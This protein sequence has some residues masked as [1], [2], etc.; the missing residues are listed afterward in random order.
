[1][2]EN[3]EAKDSSEEASEPQLGPRATKIKERLR[4]NIDDDDDLVISKEDSGV[5]Y[6][7]KAGKTFTDALHAR[8]KILHSLVK[9]GCTM[10]GNVEVAALSGEVNAVVESECRQEAWRKSLQED[11]EKTEKALKKMNDHWE[12]AATK[13]KI[14]EDL[15]AS[16]CQLKQWSHELTDQKLA[17]IEGLRGE[18][19]ELESTY[20]EEILEHARERAELLR[21]ITEHVTEL[22]QSYRA[23]LREVQDVADKE[24]RSLVKH[25]SGVWDES[26]QQL[27]DQMQ[28]LLHQRLSNR[29]ART[30]QIIELKLHGAAP[31]TAI[32]DK[33]DS[34]IEKVLV[35]VMRIKAAQQMEESQLRYNQHVLQQQYRETTALVSEGR[36]S[37]NALM[38]TLNSFRRK[39]EAAEEGRAHSEQT[40]LREIA[41]IKE[42]TQQYRSRLAKTTD[43][44]TRQS[45]GL[46][47]MHYGIMHDLVTKI[48]DTERAIQHGVLAREWVEP[49]L[50][51]LTDLCP[52]L[53]PRHTPALAA[54][55]RILAPPEEDSLE[56]SVSGE[57]SA[58]EEFLSALAVEAVFLVDEDTS[59]M[60]HHGPLLM[61]EHIF[62]ELAI[63]TEA[64]V[65]KLLKI[66][67]RHLL[68]RPQRPRLQREEEEEEEEEVDDADDEGISLQAREKLFS[69]EDILTILVA[70]SS[71][72][73]GSA[74]VHVEGKDGLARPPE[75]AEEEEEG[76]RWQNF[77]SAFCKR[78]QAW[79]TIRD[80]LTQ[81]H[82]VLTE[83]LEET[84]RVEALRREN[85]ELRYLL[86]DVSAEE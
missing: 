34:D 46:A 80:A 15:H 6:A 17:V 64:D 12:H 75:Y 76:T 29:T 42:L 24:R 35:E 47:H 50:S 9:Q 43:V 27:N 44:Y 84:K 40:A 73:G 14:P 79:S 22:H 2:K 86:Q 68:N 57:T 71:S 3:A 20:S 55:S 31:H 21:R 56:G 61:L 72:R 39:V 5:Q 60:Q 66:A 38:P 65:L 10:V 77:I 19:R 54:A 81:Y 7:N 52:A 67:R 25:Y 36:R 26:V 1:M 59:H 32:K 78:S 41:R 23:A 33:L 70:F 85:A 45:R 11:A 53:N 49:D 30:D 62:W 82:L 13:L 63:R 74:A 51:G 37:L 18:L 16:L 83:R 69:A 8:E 4:H 58:D 48:V 28:Q